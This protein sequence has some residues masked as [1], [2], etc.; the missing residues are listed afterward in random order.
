MVLNFQIK[1]KFIVI[2]MGFENLLLIILFPI[3]S[4]VHVSAH[5][6]MSIFK[7]STYYINFDKTLVLC[8]FVFV[9][10]YFIIFNIILILISAFC[11]LYLFKNS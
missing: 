5:L 9:F 11:C 3:I 2:P 1:I 8:L 4:I 6:K 10:L 7:R